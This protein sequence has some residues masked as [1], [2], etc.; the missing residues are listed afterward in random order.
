MRDY[1]ARLRSATSQLNAGTAENR[2]ELVYGLADGH[3]QEQT[4]A[5]AAEKENMDL[6]TIQKFV[7][8]KETGKISLDSIQGGGGANKLSVYR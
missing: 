1:G 7:E 3:I 5:H 2:R 8:A 6:R 4:L